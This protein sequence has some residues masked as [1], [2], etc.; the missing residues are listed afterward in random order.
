[1]IVM[2]PA[3]DSTGLRASLLLP[4]S[5]LQYS[6]HFSSVQHQR[7]NTIIRVLNSDPRKKRP[8][9]FL[10]G[11]VEQDRKSTPRCKTNGLYISVSQQRMKPTSKGVHAHPSCYSKREGPCTPQHIQQTQH[12]PSKPRVSSSSIITCTSGALKPSVKHAAHC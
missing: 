11:F 3:A 10:V 6:V 12:W 5:M 9:R 8:Q 1:M 2:F 7:I 4:R